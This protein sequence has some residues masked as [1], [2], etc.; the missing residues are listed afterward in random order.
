MKAM[1]K[2]AMKHVIMISLLLL[3]GCTLG[4]IQI[5]HERG[6]VPKVH[7]NTPADACKVRSKSKEI[8]LNCEWKF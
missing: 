4:P 3:T 2:V 1:I 7:V 5:T 6:E 8:K